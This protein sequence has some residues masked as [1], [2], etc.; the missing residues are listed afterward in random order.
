MK[1][2]K[3]KKKLF[4]GAMALLAC[5]ALVGIGQDIVAPMDGNPPL[6]GTVTIKKA[7]YAQ[8][9]NVLTKFSTSWE[10][11]PYMTKSFK[12]SG[13]GSD[14]V[15]VMFQGQWSSCFGQAAIR[16][17]IDGVLE[18]DTRFVKGDPN[19]NDTSTNGFIWTSR[20][21]K[22]GVTH[23]ATIKW[24]TYQTN[25]ASVLGPSMVIFHR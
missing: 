13:T 21:L 24:L 10:D 17:F 2:G 19:P 18:G 8:Y 5:L 22:A 11:M 16:L 3:M 4:L 20:P 7:D 23:T 25:G 14:E 9:N 15:I 12:I 1:E 6:S